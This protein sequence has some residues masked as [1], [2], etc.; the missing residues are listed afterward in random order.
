[1]EFE[2]A[3]DMIMGP[4]AEDTLKFDKEVSRC[5]CNPGVRRD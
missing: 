1:M 5:R 3:E 2:D 4:H